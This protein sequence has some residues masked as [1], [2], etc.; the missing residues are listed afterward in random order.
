MLAQAQP[1]FIG[2]RRLRTPA[3]VLASPL[4]TDELRLSL[5]MHK[6]SLS[7]PK[8]K[9]GMSMLTLAAHPEAALDVTI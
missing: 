1:Y 3:T 5:C 9:L 2:P 4:W 7:A 6:L 8:K